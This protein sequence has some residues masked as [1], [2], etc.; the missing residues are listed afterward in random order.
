MEVEGV[1][2]VGP[3]KMN[4][5]ALDI[6]NPQLQIPLGFQVQRPTILIAEM[7]INAPAKI[8]IF[9]PMVGGSVEFVEATLASD[10]IGL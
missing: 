3:L 2:Y 10:C 5:I 7:V 6:E 1:L 4:H 8:H 9:V